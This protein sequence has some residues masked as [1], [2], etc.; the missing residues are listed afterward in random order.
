MSQWPYV[1]GTWLITAVVLVT[2]AAIVIVRGRAL[3][4]RV[5]PEKRRWM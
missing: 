1:I 2:Y 4:R 5:P 3:S